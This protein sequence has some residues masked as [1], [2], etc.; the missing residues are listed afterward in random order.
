LSPPLAGG[1]YLEPRKT[2]LADFLGRWLDHI[3]S[4]VSPKTYERY[5]ELVN[6]NI[7][8]AMGA[9]QLSR[10]KPAQISDAYAKALS[11]AART[12]KLAV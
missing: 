5:S 11:G 8:P 10:L 7:I 9:L 1:S 2:T 12:K 4:Q 6:K 3:K